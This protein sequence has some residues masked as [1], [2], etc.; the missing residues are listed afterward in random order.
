M[1]LDVA[2]T[3]PGSGGDGPLP[4]LLVSGFAMMPRFVTAVGGWMGY[5]PPSAC[6]RGAPRLSVWVVHGHRDSEISWALARRSYDALGELYR[7]SVV[8]DRVELWEDEDHW[9]LWEAE[10]MGSVLSAFGEALAA[11]SAGP[12][13]GKLAKS[14]RRAALTTTA[15][16]LEDVE[17]RH[18]NR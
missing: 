7:E 6:L 2:L 4:V 1:A 9:S 3:L 8:L 16:A 15:A 5:L 11:S 12:G 18:E 10:G 17:N 14:M 13:G